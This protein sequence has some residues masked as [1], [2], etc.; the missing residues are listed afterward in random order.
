MAIGSIVA[1][2]AEIDRLIEKAAEELEMEYEGLE[3]KLTISEVLRIFLEKVGM[4][5]GV[6]NIPIGQMTVEQY[7]K[8]DAFFDMIDM[9]CQEFV[10]ADGN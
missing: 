5:K 4:P 3:D 9:S 8:V 1:H 6:W 2:D 10:P 7:R